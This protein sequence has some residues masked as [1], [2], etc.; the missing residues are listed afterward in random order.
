MQLE[1][2]GYEVQFLVTD[3]SKDTAIQLKNYYDA[4]NYDGQDS[5][6]YVKIYPNQLKVGILYKNEKPTEK[7][8]TENP[9]EPS[10]FQF[11]ILNF[12]LNQPIYILENGYFYDQNDIS[13]SGYW[14][15]EK[16]ANALP[17]DYQEE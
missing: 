16:I 1:E 6:D 8:I 14:S 3:N 17:Y 7:Y 2:S 5:T 9:T 12:Q 13:V 4:L 15:W 11:S 10:L